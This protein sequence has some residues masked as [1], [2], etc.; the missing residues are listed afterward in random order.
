M[1]KMKKPLLVA[2]FAFT[3]LSVFS[4]SANPVKWNYSAKKVADKTYEV[5]L[6][7]SLGNEW[8]IYSQNIQV[9]LPVAT[10]VTFTKNPM[11]I[12]DGKVNEVG[13]LIKKNEEVLGGIVNYYENSVDF[14]QKVKLKGNTKTNL[15]GK[16]EYVVCNSVRCLPP[17][18]A[19]FSV[20]IG[21]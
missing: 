3:V 13:K 14:V 2:F 6:T 10:A 17:S 19:T 12:I 20:N 8:H 11:I 1:Y 7:V 21:G 4:Q 9:D 18:E 5:H 15:A 16:V